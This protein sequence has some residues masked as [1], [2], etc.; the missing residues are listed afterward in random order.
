MHR[1]LLDAS[2]TCATTK[3][4]TERKSMRI[5]WLERLDLASTLPSAAAHNMQSQLSTPVGQRSRKAAPPKGESVQV[6]LHPT[7]SYETESFHAWPCVTG[8]IMGNRSK[9]AQHRQRLTENG[10]FSLQEAFPIS[11]PRDK[12]RSGVYTAFLW[13][14]QLQTTRTRFPACQRARKTKLNGVQGQGVSTGG[15]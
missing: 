9:N 13:L 10:P 14:G 12:R 4:R 7:V 6:P 1:Y 3:H 8:S 11:Q 2:G 5:T 15:G